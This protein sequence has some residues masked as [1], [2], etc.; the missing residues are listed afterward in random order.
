[1]R[2]SHP[3]SGASVYRARSHL[4][5]APLGSGYLR[6]ASVRAV[7]PSA[8]SEPIE[9]TFAKYHEGH[10]TSPHLLAGVAGVGLSLKSVAA[11]KAR[12]S[13]GQL[14]NPKHNTVMACSLRHPL[15]LIGAGA[16]VRGHHLS[17]GSGNEALHNHSVEATNCSK[18]QFAPHLKR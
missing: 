17:S 3:A 18:L 5:R 15:C 1:M 13:S 9:V 8:A 14:P 16:A 11:L 10:G 2:S 7:R 4:H 12:L 6:L